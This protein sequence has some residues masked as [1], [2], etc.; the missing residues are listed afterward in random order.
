M[1]IVVREKGKG[2]KFL[3]L[4]AKEGLVQ[5]NVKQPDGTTVKEMFPAGTSIEGLL[6]KFEVK[7]DEY[8]GQTNYILVLHMDDL[9]P[10][11]S[12]MQVEATF[13]SKEKGLSAF[14]LGLLARL[15]SAELNKPLSIQP[16]F[17]AA[18]STYKKKDGTVVTR[19]R[20]SVTVNVWQD[21]KPMQ[22][23]YADGSDR[24]PPLP[25]NSRGAVSDSVLW[26]PIGD[27]LV[28]AMAAKID[29]MHGPA[30]AEEEVDVGEV[31]ATTNGD[32]PAQRG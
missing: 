4:N 2:V 16:K 21:R 27:A 14:G 6:T 28:A 7:E 19:D 20:D 17:E 22:A 15:N 31:L 30:D 3:K 32:R 9:D 13:G 12:R 24:L 18:G 8:N 5:Q 25:R 11:E 29:A 1:G 23:L 10:N 26:D